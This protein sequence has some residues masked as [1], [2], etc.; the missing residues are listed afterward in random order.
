MK[1]LKRF[2]ETFF[3]F[4]EIVDKELIQQVIDKM[5][6]NNDNKLS[7][8]FKKSIIEFNKKY[9]IKESK[10]LPETM[11]KQ[12]A[13]WVDMDIIQDCIDRMTDK[14]ISDKYKNDLKNFLK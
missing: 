4:S 12:V 14:I 2:N 5:N 1:H 13:W 6:P 7:D 9:P 10:R 3:Y 11:G 8:N